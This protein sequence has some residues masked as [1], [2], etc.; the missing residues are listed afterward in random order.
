MRVLAFVLTIPQSCQA[1][2]RAQLSGFRLPAT[3]L[4]E[5]G[6]KVQFA[7]FKVAPKR[8]HRILEQK[9]SVYA[10]ADANLTQWREERCHHADAS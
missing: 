2:G 10:K 4:V 6:W 9:T 8:E 3:G 1:G 7:S 5:G